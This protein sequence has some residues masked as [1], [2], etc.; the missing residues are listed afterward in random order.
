MFPSK[1]S[2]DVH[3]RVYLTGWTVYHQKD[4]STSRTLA[5]VTTIDTKNLTIES[6]IAIC[7]NAG[8]IFAGVEFGQECYC[9]SVIQDPGVETD[10][11]EC[12]FACS[13]NPA[14]VCGSGGHMNIFYSGAPLPQFTQ[15]IG[16]TG[17]TFQGCFTDDPQNRTLR[18]PVAIPQGVTP[19]SC[20]A[21]CQT[22]GGFARAGLEVGREC[23]CDNLLDAS[24][25]AR[26]TRECRTVCNADHTQLCGSANRAAVYGFN[27]GGGGTQPEQC[28]EVNVNNFTLQAVFKAPPPS[29]PSTITLKMILVEMVP[30]IMWSILSACTN[31]CTDWPNFSLT[32]SVFLPRSVSNPAQLVS[33][34]PR[35]GE[36]LSF[37]A[38]SPPFPGDRG[39]C[40]TNDINQP[41]GL[42]LLAFNGNSENWALCPNNTANGRLDVVFSPTLNHPHYTVASCLAVDIQMIGV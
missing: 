26:P 34:T 36:S 25:E 14:E 12:N 40:V 18:V 11:S 30:D 22:A 1:F 5:A 37:L 8:F 15:T 32:N 42:P 20:T 6:C 16:E 24:S 23:W 33:A 13:G 35:A 39:Y 27:V 28:T 10:I 31:C 29:G 9:D 19:E 7:D 38:S 21:A 2:L 3:W 17:W 4:I 41:D